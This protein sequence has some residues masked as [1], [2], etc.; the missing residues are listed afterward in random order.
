MCFLANINI[1]S[2]LYLGNDCSNLISA[3]EI[4][5]KKSLLKNNTVVNKK[6]TPLKFNIKFIYT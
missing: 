3:K 4:I 5:Y 2:W 1:E 6:Y